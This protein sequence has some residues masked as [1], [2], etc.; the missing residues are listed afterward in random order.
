MKRQFS[1]LT[2]D[3][4][5]RRRNK[6][7]ITD[8]QKDNRQVD[9]DATNDCDGVQ[10]RTAHTNK[11]VKKNNP[12]RICSRKTSGLSADNPGKMYSDHIHIQPFLFI[13][14]IFN[15]HSKFRIEKSCPLVVFSIPHLIPS[16]SRNKSSLFLRS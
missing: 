7:S 10:T 11:S 15:N 16:Q 2:H 5:L 6:V 12:V 4:V 3:G 9:E 13:C 8:A 14:T 1:N